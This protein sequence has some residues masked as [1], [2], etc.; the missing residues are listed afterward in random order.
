MSSNPL[1]MGY[2]GGD[3]LLTGAAWPTVG[4]LPKPVCRL[5]AVA[6]VAGGSGQWRER[7]RGGWSTRC[8]IQ[9]EALPLPDELM[10]LLNSGCFSTSAVSKTNEQ[11]EMVNHKHDWRRKHRVLSGIY[12]ERLDERPEKSSDTLT[13]TQ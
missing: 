10:L 11:V 1:M 5:W 13:S 12:L 3:L 6:W 4:S 8:A 9:I 7:I 2:K